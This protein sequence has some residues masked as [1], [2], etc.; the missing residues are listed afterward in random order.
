VPFNELI[1]R[2]IDMAKGRIVI[3]PPRYEEKS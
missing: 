1:V 3:D 2:E